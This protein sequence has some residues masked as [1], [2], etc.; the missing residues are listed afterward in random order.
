MLVY[1]RV[2]PNRMPMGANVTSMNCDLS[3]MWVCLKIGYLLMAYHAIIFL[4][5]P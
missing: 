2:E 5:K 4:L 1:Q 3:I